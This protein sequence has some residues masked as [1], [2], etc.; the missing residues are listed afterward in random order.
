MYETVAAIVTLL[1]LAL[2]SS[3][4]T[5]QTGRITLRESLPLSATRHFVEEMPAVVATVKKGLIGSSLENAV[6]LV[7]N[8]DY[9]PIS[10][11]WFA[12]KRTLF[13]IS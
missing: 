11:V 9:K 10:Y 1:N 2:I 13:T 5:S 12:L 7:L 3:L 4:P 8:A 6:T